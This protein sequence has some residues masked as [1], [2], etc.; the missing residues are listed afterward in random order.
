MEERFVVLNG[1]KQ[2]GEWS[3]MTLIILDFNTLYNWESYYRGVYYL[4]Y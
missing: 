3:L 4:F 1:S 2:G